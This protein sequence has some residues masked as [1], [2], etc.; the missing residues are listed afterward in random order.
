MRLLR[1]ELRLRWIS[2]LLWTVAVAL[3]VLLLIAFYPSVRDDPSLNAI[4]AGLSDSAQGLLGG[5]DLTSP[6]GYLSTQLFAF[7]LPIV[8]LV[9]GLAR[10]AASLAGEEEDRTLDLLLAQPV[11]RWSA[12]LQKSAALFVGLLL[13]T[14]ASWLPLVLLGP[15]VRLDLPW[16][17]TLAVCVQMGLFALALTLW[18]QA[19]AAATGRRGVGLAVV[20]GYA[21]LAYLVYGL[22]D[23]VSWLAPIK[24]LSLWRWYLGNDPLDTGF[25][26]A[27]ILVLLLTSLAA[28]AAGTAL[29]ARR[30][31]RA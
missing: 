12:Y 4:Y 7:F 6:S 26:A 11:P 10:G 9:F 2:L 3:V 8:L 19:I 27:E 16:T 21:F 30:D 24:G 15:A 25:G 20:S 31:L 22:A 17:Q 18:A 13:L 23:T 1:S 5:S 28:L 29:F 14:L